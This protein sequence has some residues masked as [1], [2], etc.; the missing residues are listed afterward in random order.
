MCPGIL[1]P[2]RLAPP[3]SCSCTDTLVARSLWLVL[4]LWNQTRGRLGSQWGVGE[5]A[6]RGE[7]GSGARLQET[8]PI[9]TTCRPAGS[10]LL[11]TPG[12]SVHGAPSSSDIPALSDF[13]LLPL[14]PGFFCPHVL[15]LCSG[16]AAPQ[17]SKSVP[18]APAPDMVLGS[19]T[20]GTDSL[21]VE[22]HSCSVQG[23]WHH[24]PQTQARQLGVLVDVSFSSTFQS[25]IRPPRASCLPQQCSLC[26]H[27]LCP[28][29]LVLRALPSL[30]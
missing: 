17:H 29:S 8:W 22:P 3:S 5:G 1:P 28:P 9:P 18:S 4:A 25:Q 7:G 2:F 20:R 10:C 24:L 14:S 11:P 26:F 30:S 16:Q 21:L 27:L 12:L 19:G 15:L 6:G 13:L 23:E